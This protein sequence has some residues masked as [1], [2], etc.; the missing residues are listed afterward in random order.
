[1]T[2]RSL[3]APRIDNAPLGIVMMLG[4]VLLFSLM[5]VLVKLVAATYPVTEVVFFRSLIAL[6]PV[7]LTVAMQGGASSLR[8]ARPLGH[9][10]RSTVGMATMFLMFWSVDLL[11]LAD[12]TALNFTSPLFLTALSV[13]LLGER[14]GVHR[15]SA[16][17][18]GFVGVLILVRPGSDVLEIGSLVAI[19]AALGQALAM[20][21]IRQLSGTDS[22]NTI[23][24]YF[25]V[26]CTAISGFTLPFA[27][28]TPTWV[29]LGVL[30]AIGILG[31]GAQLLVTRAYTLTQAAVVAPFTYTSIVFAT[32]F[33]WLIW[34]E[35]P[36]AWS[37]VGI[38]IVVASGLYILHR[39]K[40]RR[41]AVVRAAA[42]A[43]GED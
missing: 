14:V 15:W 30:T 10:W 29:D 42:P 12:A 8:T 1:M 16:V 43:A 13:P 33:G 23:A 25:T 28:V 19:G 7:G 20:I 36:D 27:W 18:V 21:A 37:W 17:A 35:L 38:A 22:P 3:P 24:F 34:N 41:A 6:I 40:R 4:S 32:F 31:G 5:N 26:A 2:V 9:L 11:P 39:E